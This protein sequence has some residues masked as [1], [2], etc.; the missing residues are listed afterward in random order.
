LTNAI[1]ALKIRVS[2]RSGDHMTKFFIILIAG[3]LPSLSSFASDKP[4]VTRE[5]NGSGY[6]NTYTKINE[7]GSCQKFK[8]SAQNYD[9]RNVEEYN[10][11][12]HLLAAEQCK[13][14]KART[15]AARQFLTLGLGCSVL[16]TV[17]GKSRTPSLSK[18]C[19]CVSKKFGTFFKSEVDFINPIQDCIDQFPVENQKQVLEI[20]S[21]LSK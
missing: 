7:D 16:P 17:P 18:D 21:E 11:E 4:M 2:T 14:L 3:V 9:Q 19:A 20:E 8:S 12:Q 15:A 10:G 13:T 6:M 1:S 5:F